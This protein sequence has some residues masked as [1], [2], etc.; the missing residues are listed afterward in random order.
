MANTRFTEPSQPYKV[1]VSTSRS[2]STGVT[3][4]TT[5]KTTNGM[6][7]RNRVV[8][9][10]TWVRTPNYRHIIAKGLTLPDNSFYY[11]EQKL[12]DDYGT[13][14]T[15]PVNTGFAVQS[16]VRTYGPHA[17][18]GIYVPTTVLPED[19]L[20]GSLLRKA[21]SQQW[22]APVFVAEAHKTAS[23]VYSRAVHL[24]Q[25]VN[26]LRS[27]NFVGFVQMFH[28]SVSPSKRPGGRAAKRYAGAYGKDA[29]GAAGNAWLEYQYGWKP[30]MKDVQDAVNTLMDVVDLP[31]RRTATV[32]AS[33]KTARSTT[34][35][36]VRIFIDDT[37]NVYIRGDLIQEVE[38]SLRV[39]WRL[40]PNSSDL[41]ARFGLV[42][43]LE[44]VWELVPF[45]FVADWFIPIGDYLS[46]LDA[47]IRFNHLGGT[48]GRR[49]VSKLTQIGR[50]AETSSQ[51]ISGFAGHGKRT[52]IQRTKLYAM[53]SVGIETLV[54]NAEL[55]EKR[56]ASAIALLQQQ[57]SRL[58]R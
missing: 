22:N 11:E 34:S 2:L 40:T 35:K 12:T 32:R 3:T 36:D 48:V 47:P 55:T 33:R 28:S 23:M 41:P 43:P 13:V 30:F 4:V 42:N 7:V 24:A 25:M 52:Y 57:L 37:E 15:G 38:E 54:F 10:K 27:G 39:T 6:S 46:A 49:M 45:S 53:P 26:A 18:S 58:K 50:R 8:R 17:V 9:D 51:R 14:S 56:V 44:V 29:R 31:Q 21:K 5:T 16:D 20:S 19:S 1:K